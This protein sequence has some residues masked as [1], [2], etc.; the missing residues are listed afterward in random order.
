MLDVGQRI[1]SNNAVQVIVIITCFILAFLAQNLSVNLSHIPLSQFI[2]ISIDNIFAKKETFSIWLNVVLPAVMYLG[3]CLLFLW[4]GIT[5][6]LSFKGEETAPRSVLRF[7]LAAS[8]ILLFGW[9]LFV[10]GKLFIY[11]AAFSLLI[12]FLGA[13]LIGLFSSDNRRENY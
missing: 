4:M 1:F 13:G 8:Q 5:N 10:G 6:F 2:S 12:L 11:I 3:I 7:L 9:F